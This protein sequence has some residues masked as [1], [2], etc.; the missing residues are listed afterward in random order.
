MLISEDLEVSEDVLV[1]N[2]S[3]TAIITMRSKVCFQQNL[4]E[5]SPQTLLFL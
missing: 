2:V 3:T 1:K 4:V 5:A